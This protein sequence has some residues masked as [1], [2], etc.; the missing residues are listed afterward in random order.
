M[1]Q[2]AKMVYSILLF[3][4]ALFFCAQSM[5]QPSK[6][7]IACAANFSAT[8]D[9]LVN[10]FQLQMSKSTEV[11]VVTGS[12][13]ALASQ[14][15]HGAPFDVYFSAD[16][17]LPQRLKQAGLGY[18][19]IVYAK[20]ELV[21]Y[22]SVQNEHLLSDWRQALSTATVAIANPKLAPYGRAALQVL[23]TQNVTPQRI[24]QGTSV[25]QA[26]QFVESGHAQLGLIAKSLLQADHLGTYIP[27]PIE[28]Y[29]PIEQHALL[30]T[31]HPSAKAFFDFVQSDAAKQL[32]N[33]S[34]YR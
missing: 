15:Q 26:F 6:L 4:F 10:L 19:S 9:K 1:W 8:M 11:R 30:L 24:V 13:G 5:A 28:W 23:Q 17:A 2:R 33:A 21:L 29:E 3:S 7:T 20:G 34:G 25:L 32:I 14:I 16:H 18:E 31:P 27:L 22:A 12:S